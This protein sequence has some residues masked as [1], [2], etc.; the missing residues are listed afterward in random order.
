[1]EVPHADTVLPGFDGK[2]GVLAAR[3][4]TD[5]LFFNNDIFSSS[6]CIRWSAL[7]WGETGYFTGS[8]TEPKPMMH[9][10]QE[11][12]PGTTTHQFFLFIF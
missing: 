5:V 7:V 6:S 9:S 3:I 11:C 12:R 10:G 4:Q 1:M 8:S 2:S